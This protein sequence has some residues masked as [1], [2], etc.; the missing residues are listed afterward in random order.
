LLA[1]S[2]S[3]SFGVFSRRARNVGHPLPGSDSSSQLWCQFFHT[4]PIRQ[5]LL[6]S[7]TL[8][9]PPRH[10]SVS[11]IISGFVC[12]LLVRTPRGHDCSSPSNPPFPPPP[13]NPMTRYPPAGLLDHSR[14][15]V[16]PFFVLFL[17]SRQFPSFSESSYPLK[18]SSP[19]A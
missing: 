6:E 13:L 14:V 18:S 5:I 12:T 1:P 7:F 16:P 17:R 4:V 11:I 3:G 10:N 15:P 8:S 2:S 19:F 9:P